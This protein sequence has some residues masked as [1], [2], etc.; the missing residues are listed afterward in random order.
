MKGL[1]AEETWA[2]VPGGLKGEAR[3]AKGGIGWP[4]GA[5]SVNGDIRAEGPEE[6]VGRRA[7]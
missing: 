6:S 4:K 1:W 2:R 3:K 7:G 5:A